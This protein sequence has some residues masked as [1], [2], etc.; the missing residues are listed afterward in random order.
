MTGCVFLVAGGTGGHVFPALALA[1]ALAQKE[2]RC[3]FIGDK[4]TKNLYERNQRDVQLIT[5]A[6]IG[7]GLFGKLRAVFFII[8]GI[9]ESL[10]VLREEKP[11]V[12]VGFGGYPSFPMV[13]AAQ[14]LGIPTL[15]HEQNAVL[16][17]ANR[18]LLKR[19]KKLALSFNVVKNI[20][21][22]YMSKAVMTGNPIR[23]VFTQGALPYPSLAGELHIAITGGSQ[24][25]AFFNQVIPNA[26]ALLPQELRDRLRITQQVRAEAMEQVRLA[27]GTM[28]VKAVLAPFFD[29]MIAFFRSAHLVIGRAGA[30]TVA[31]IMAVGRPA[32][33]VPLAISLDGDQAQNAA[34]LVRQNAAWVLTEKEATPE[35]LAAHL[36]QLLLHPQLL[37]NAASAAAQCGRPQAAFALADLVVSCQKG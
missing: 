10:D 5:A 24:G 2:V 19:A 30:G 33:F 28:G 37:A 29:D 3:V 23:S 26:I 20:L 14:I 4:R 21:P 35:K 34:Q 11:D 15:L 13:F 8:A 16:G 12:V 36:A 31:E 1:D 22:Q 25:S 17:R 9:I 6:T 32:L 7:P 27:Y 18:M